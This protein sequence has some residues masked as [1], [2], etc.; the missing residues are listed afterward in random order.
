M[1]IKI[2]IFSDMLIKLYNKLI[3]IIDRRLVKNYDQKIIQIMS[4][5]SL[6]KEQKGKNNYKTNEY[7][8]IKKLIQ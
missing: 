8:H 5:D 6:S 2:F 3:Q 7:S 4:F 1:I